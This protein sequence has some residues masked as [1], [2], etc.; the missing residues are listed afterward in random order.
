MTFR[1]GLIVGGAVGYVFGTRA[2]QERYEQIQQAYRKL[3]QSETAQKMTA[4]VR[5][6]AS[7][8][9]ER[10]ET[11]ATESVSRVTGKVRGGEDSG[12]PSTTEGGVSTEPRTLPPS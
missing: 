8:T 12:S 2:G 1:L 11:K 5:D 10:L 3:K 4:E 9:G 7:Q 6:L